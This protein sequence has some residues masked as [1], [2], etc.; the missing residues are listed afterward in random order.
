METARLYGWTNARI[1]AATDVGGY[2]AIAVARKGKDSVIGIKLGR[3]SHADADKRA[4]EQC[5][6]ADGTDV[7]VR[8]RFNG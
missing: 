3:P 6:K 1:V 2:G 7:Q 5:L 8:W 4:I